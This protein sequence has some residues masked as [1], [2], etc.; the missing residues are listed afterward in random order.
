MSRINV[1][2]YINQFFA[3]LGGEERAS[4]P[5]GVQEGP[6]GPGR[7]LQSLFAEK[8][9]VIA[10]VYC[11]DNYISER[12]ELAT[13]EIVEM[14][15]RFQPSVVIAG[16]AFSSGRYGLSCGRICQAVQQKLG[17]P[18]VTGMHEEN[19]G[20]DLYRAKVYIAA[21]SDRASGMEEAM[22]VMTRLA[23]KLA[24][25]KPLG[26]AAEE[27]YLPTGQR[28]NIFAA[29]SGAERALDMLSKK[30]KGETFV[31]EWPLPKYDQVPS[32]PA[33]ADLSKATIALVTEGGLVPKGNPDR[34]ESAWA[35]KWA[36]YSIKG[37]TVLSNQSYQCVHGGF[38]TTLINEDPHRLLPLDVM[39]D[40]EREGVFG[41]LH[42]HYY[43]TV[44]NLGSI[45]T[46]KEIG[47]EVAK[48]LKA[49]NVDGVVLPA[50]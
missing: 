28:Q 19:P 31:T 35:T 34:I 41:K 16:P 5:P 11:G 29:K 30:M 23:V 37:V 8:G 13:S 32:A 42:D 3:G 50:T 26:P 20:V 44:G 15:A 9:K 48:E 2:H 4:T 10:T 12:E 27:G 6:I 25:G 33:I 21:T 18:A 49:A 1:V 39:L 7:L 17:I 22:S 38:D 46:M 40:M 43:V 47:A 45:S 14:I 24:S 36:K